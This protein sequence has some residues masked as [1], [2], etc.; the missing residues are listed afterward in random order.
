[1]IYIL[2][3]DGFEEIEALVP[4]DILIRAKIDVQLIG[5][6]SSL[7]K[8]ANGLEIK[9]DKIID[10]IMFDSLEGIILPGG[11]PGTKN[12][13]NNNKV[14]TTID[15]CYKNNLM[16]AAICA[17]P[18]ILGNMGIL[19]GKESC[20]YPGFEEY[21]KQSVV[22]EKNV[23]VCQNVITSRGPG[24]SF[25]FAFAILEYLRGSISKS[26]V[27]SQIQYKI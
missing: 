7:V 9:T 10:D 13:Q 20:C 14:L 8:S 25:D 22:N 15:F 11:M 17:A 24:T 26:K 4:R 16:I 12:L 5:L 19:E 18:M 27:C 23:N 3:A 6:N 21:L 1:M 2:L